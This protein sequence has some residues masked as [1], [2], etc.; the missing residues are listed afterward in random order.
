M[1]NFDHKFTQAYLNLIIIA[2]ELRE[3]AIRYVQGVIM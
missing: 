3:Y 1:I 2:I